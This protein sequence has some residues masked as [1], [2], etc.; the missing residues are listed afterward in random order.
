MLSKTVVILGA[1]AASQGVSAQLKPVNQAVADGHLPAA[2]V[3][4]V[5]EMCGSLEKDPKSDKPCTIEQVENA[6]LVAIAELTDKK[7]PEKAKD[8]LE[9]YWKKSPLH[10]A[11]SCCIQ[12]K[13]KA[14]KSGIKQ[15]GM[16]PAEGKWFQSEFYSTEKYF[17]AWEAKDADYALLMDEWKWRTTNYPWVNHDVTKTEEQVGFKFEDDKCAALGSKPKTR[18][19]R[20]AVGKEVVCPTIPTVIHT[21]Q[22][23]GNNA[24]KGLAAKVN[25]GVQVSIAAFL[26]V[27]IVSARVSEKEVTGQVYHAPAQKIEQAPTKAAV[28]SLPPQVIRQDECKPCAAGPAKPAAQI[29]QAPPPTAQEIKLSAN[30]EVNFGGQPAAGSYE[31]APESKDGSKPLSRKPREATDGPAVPSSA[32]PEPK[33]GVKPEPKAGVK[34]ELK[35]PAA[36]NAAAAA[37]DEVEAC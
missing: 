20:E 9:T 36:G 10:E 4:S 37:E 17:K 5:D 23:T 12:C 25:P 29:L 34:P 32:K 19:P 28:K 11:R 6:K 7:N 27:N 35:T 16:S 3:K 24:T 31:G 22:P 14:F 26:Q 33:T 30:V 18:V 2:E 15:G 13:V 8:W 21:Y 1:L